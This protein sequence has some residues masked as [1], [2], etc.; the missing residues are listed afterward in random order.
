VG[1]RIGRAGHFIAVLDVSEGQV[2]VADP[3]SGEERLTLTEFKRAHCCPKQPNGA[4]CAVDFVEVFWCF[5]RFAERG[6]P[7]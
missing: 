6:C 4:G 2:T 5:L 7:V 1:V 3:L